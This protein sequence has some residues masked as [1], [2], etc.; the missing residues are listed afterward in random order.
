MS[1][2]EI[3]KN[4]TQTGFSI[5]IL[6]PLKGKNLNKV[7]ADLD[8]LVEHKPLFVNI[9]THHSEPVYMAAGDDGNLRKVFVRK[10]PGT[11]AV[12]AAI[13]H[14]Y[15]IPTVPH[16]ICMGF[17]PEETEYVLI[18][19]NFL[20]VTDLLVL[21]GDTDKETLV[22]REASHKFAIDLIQ[23]VNDFNNGKSI[24]GSLFEK[25]DV[26]FSYGVAGYPE[27]H[28]EAPNLETDIQRLKAKV[29]MGAQYVVTQLF[30]DN[31]HF[32]RFRDKAH[33]AGINVPIIPGLK[34]LSKKK[35]L[36]ILPSVFN[37]EIPQPLVQQVEAAKDDSESRKIGTDWLFRQ[38]EDLKA[39]GVPCIHYY[40][41]GAVD[42]VCDV[43]KNLF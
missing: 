18:D 30:Y 26:P 9:T 13:R 8:K 38:S 6:P 37:T 2:A 34:P 31:D 3:L 7:F 42:M 41:L 43:V 17:S 20:G 5:E 29:D 27:K 40:T 1:V 15:N 36:S 22:P 23:Q 16:I 21:R 19:L 10:R 4:R 39:H 28:S 25:P 11:V 12:A 14:R 32:Y 33:A 24:D 35:Q